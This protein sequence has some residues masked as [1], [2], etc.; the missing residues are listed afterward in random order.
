MWWQTIKS[1][2]DGVG[3]VD[4]GW[5]LD[6]ITR[7]MGD[8]VSTLFWADP[9]LDGKPL[10]KAF[11]RLFQLAENKFETVANMFSR[12]W[13]ANGEAWRWHQRLLAWE[14]D[15]LGKCV[16]RLTSVILQVDK[17]DR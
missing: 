3:Q 16:A 14:E 15:L 9:W 17:V 6:N 12:G 2:R 13:G 1:V 5:L 8:G 7:Q 11:M 4:S 10:C